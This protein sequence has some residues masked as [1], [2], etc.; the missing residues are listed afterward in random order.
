MCL[1]VSV[2]LIDLPMICTIVMY[3]DMYDSNVR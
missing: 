2:C 3:D 1:Y